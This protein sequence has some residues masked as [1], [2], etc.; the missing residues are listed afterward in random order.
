MRQYQLP[1]GFGVGGNYTFSK[2][3]GNVE[4]E[5]SGGGPGTFANLNVAYSECHPRRPISVMARNSTPLTKTDPS[6][7]CQ[8]I[9]SAARR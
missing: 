8:V 6:R 9:P 4:G 3:T 5:S 7:C 1:A 2:L